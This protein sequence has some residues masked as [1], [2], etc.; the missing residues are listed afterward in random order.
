MSDEGKK[1]L[2]RKLLHEMLADAFDLLGKDQ[3]LMKVSASRCQLSG[4]SE[5]ENTKLMLLSRFPVLNIFI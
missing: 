4:K 3:T 1:S 5:T 2:E